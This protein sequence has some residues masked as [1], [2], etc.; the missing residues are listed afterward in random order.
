MIAVM[1][2]LVFIYSYNGVCIKF[3]EE[4]WKE[5]ETTVTLDWAYSTLIFTFKR[6]DVIIY[7]T[8]DPSGFPTSVLLM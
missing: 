5:D 2:I 8:K 3:S 7:C 1:N 4:L 6:C